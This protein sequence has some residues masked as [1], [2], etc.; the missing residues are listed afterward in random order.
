M[1]FNALVSDVM[2]MMLSRFNGSTLCDFRG[3][4]TKNNRIVNKMESDF[5]YIVLV[6]SSSKAN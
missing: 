6:I 1:F 5:V 3:V 2:T 4:V